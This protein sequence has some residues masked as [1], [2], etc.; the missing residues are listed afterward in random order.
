MIFS[1][2]ALGLSSDW[3]S[4][5]KLLGGNAAQGH[6][7]E[8]GSFLALLE[9]SFRFIVPKILVPNWAYTLFPF[10]AL[11]QVKTAYDD[12]HGAFRTMIER[13]K[14][15]LALGVEHNNLF[16]ALVAGVKDEEGEG[17][18]TPDEVVSNLYIFL[19]AGH[20][21][22]SASCLRITASHDS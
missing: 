13:H 4:S 11:T 15:D 21:V 5:N 7:T 20:E 12:L 9:Q 1:G 2:A 6:A 3:P 17:V 18:L 22:S 10:R 19:V 8:A 14:A 16:S